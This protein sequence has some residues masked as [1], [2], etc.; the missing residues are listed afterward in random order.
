[1]KA[2]DGGYIL[3]FEWIETGEYNFS[4]TFTAIDFFKFMQAYV[5]FEMLQG[6]LLTIR[7][8]EVLMELGLQKP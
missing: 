8:S 1:M 6:I 4:K 3:K 2:Q 5:L 7:M